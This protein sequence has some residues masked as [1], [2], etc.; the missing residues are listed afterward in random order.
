ML[1]K[2][3]K[4]IMGN[5]LFNDDGVI[6]RPDDGLVYF[7]G[8]DDFGALWHYTFDTDSV[9]R[10]GTN[11]LVKD[12]I[13]GNHLNCTPLFG[14]PFK[15]FGIDRFGTSGTT[16]KL[17]D[18]SDTDPKV[19]LQQENSITNIIGTAFTYSFW[20]RFTNDG[21]QKPL[22]I[23][24]DI[25]T[26]GGVIITTGYGLSLGTITFS[27]NSSTDVEFETTGT[28][29][30]LWHHWVFT[31]DAN[32][33]WKRIYFDGVLA[34]E[35]NTP[36]NMYAFP[37]SDYFVSFSSQNNSIDYFYG[38]DKELTVDEI[39]YIY[40]HET[41]IVQQP[42]YPDY[43]GDIIYTFV[44]GDNKYVEGETHGIVMA[45][46]D[47]TGSTTWGSTSI[48]VT[49]SNVVGYGGINTAAIIA[50]NGSNNAAGLCNGWTYN[51][52]SDWVLPNL[53]ELYM[54]WRFRKYNLQGWDSSSSYLYWSSYQYDTSDAWY[55]EID[56]NAFTGDELNIS[57]SS[58]ISVRAIRYF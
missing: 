29:D 19:V 25:Y 7:E 16:T 42:T 41:R 32:N 26:S 33:E 57:K 54:V 34:S 53:T 36:W 51:S 3:F 31:S 56:P 24:R 43:G 15:E 35:V 21:G 30:N 8:L 46:I 6:F 38:W 50:A 52:Y 48:L 2:N 39:E 5:I 45:S 17:T 49:T 9:I 1:K 40:N 23:L 22:S 47:V 55:K 58:T 44:S 14:T 37:A 13:S 18:D 10:Y 28:T 27:C 11:G 20:A 12:Y 4:E